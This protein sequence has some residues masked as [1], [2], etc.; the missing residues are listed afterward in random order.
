MSDERDRERAK[1]ELAAADAAYAASDAA[2]VEACCE[3]WSAA[4]A[5]ARVAVAN[6]AEAGAAFFTASYAAY[7]KAL[8]VANAKFVIGMRAALA[9][10]AYLQYEAARDA[11]IDH[12][13][14]TNEA[15]QAA[16]S[17]AAQ[18]GLSGDEYVELFDK[19]FSA[20]REQEMS[21]KLQYSEAELAESDAFRDAQDKWSALRDAE[22]RIEK[23][24]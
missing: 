16:A 2:K 4:D 24:P 5:A 10:P 7:T 21:K 3:A 22:R 12:D 20:Y 15:V 17:D 8:D 13:E 1:R 19:V 9:L 6:A 18:G 11:R 23:G 14:I